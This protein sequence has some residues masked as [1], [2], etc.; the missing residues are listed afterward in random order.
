MPRR[1]L[2]SLLLTLL[3]AAAPASLLGQSA[4][5]ADSEAGVLDWR[6]DPTHSFIGFKVRHMG[7][8]TVTG[9]FKDYEADIALDP[10]DLTTL[11]ATAIVRTTSV[12]TD[13]DRRDNHLRSDD[14]F[15]AEEY[16]EMRFESREVRL[17]DDGRFELVGDLT[18]RDTTREIVLTGEFGGTVPSRGGQRM[19]LSAEGRLNRFDYG[20][21]WDSL[22]EAGGLVVSEDVR[23]VLDIAAVSR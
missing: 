21:R 15:N 8:A 18:I 9:E 14:F 5:D 2:T 3:L 17:T 10:S 12:D 16:P 20:L 23:L 22:T 13:H 19:A 11:S 1:F 6:I 4:M 7:I